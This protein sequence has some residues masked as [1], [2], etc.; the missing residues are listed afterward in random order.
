MIATGTL[1]L[2]INMPCATV[3]FV[4]DNVSLTPLNYRQAAGRAGRRGFDL[5][6]NV[7]FHGVPPERT[8]RL[9]NSNLP[10]L[11]GHFPTSTT[12]ILRLFMLLHGS[13]NASHAVN[14]VNSILSQNTLSAASDGEDFHDQVVHHIR[15]S[16]EYLRRMNL[17]GP[18]GEPTN[19]AACAAHLFYHEPSNFLFNALMREGVFHA[20]CAPLSAPGKENV[21]SELLTQEV[22]RKLLILMAHLFAREQFRDSDDPE[23]F[24]S[25]LSTSV[26]VLPDMP[27][28]AAEVV[29]KH[30]LE[31]LNVFT[32]YAVTYAAQHKQDKPDI[33]PFTQRKIGGAEVPIPGF[34][35]TLPPVQA[36]SSFTALSGHADDF[37]SIPELM[38]TC[39][40][41]I[42]LEASG[43]PYLAI[44]GIRLNAYLLDFLNHG[45]LVELVS[46]NHLPKSEVWFMLN[47]F[48]HVLAAVVVTIKNLIKVGPEGEMRMGNV[49][50]GRGVGEDVLEEVERVAAADVTDT[51]VAS[52]T[53]RVSTPVGRKKV[54]G[55]WY[56]EDAGGST[57]APT[58]STLPS[59]R[60]GA[61]YDEAGSDDE[62][63]VLAGEGS[64]DTDRQALLK[65]L[66]GFVNLQSEFNDKFRAIFATKKD[67]AR[68][69]RK[70]DAQR[71]GRTAEKEKKPRL[72]WR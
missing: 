53:P 20:V 60:F 57:P 70:L 62:D 6:G 24:K 56:D 69:R 21:D 17:L 36:R 44:D 7:I 2:G 35:R 28:D 65:V 5:L 41:D 11:M 19:F 52:G 71:V 37:H 34:L 45:S 15:F 51:A 13:N 22:N 31:S 55:N 25:E 58:S 61:E 63:D 68:V 38:S 46:A 50:V 42:L 47:E 66:K 32:T 64:E 27:Q 14:V 43:V 30:N 10:S 54:A 9:I 23:S 12:L 4:T 59:S 3:V 16:I 48:S 18:A 8:H 39:R 26:I 49:T 67:A 33:L 1:S 29:R 72:T 40:P